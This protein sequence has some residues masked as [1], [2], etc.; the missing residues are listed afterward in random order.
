MTSQQTF[1]TITRG[2]FG[3]GNR[4]AG[5]EIL[6]RIVDLDADEPGTIVQAFHLDV[7]DS[8]RFWAYELWASAEALEYHRNRQHHLH[9]QIAPLIETP[10]EVYRCLPLF[11]KGLTLPPHPS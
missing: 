3:R 6:R 2:R 10:L 11:G 7:G 4:D 5:I 8:D 9:A 1:A